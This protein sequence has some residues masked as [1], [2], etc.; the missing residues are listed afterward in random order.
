[1]KTFV[2]FA[3]DTQAWSTDVEFARRMLAGL[4]PLVITLLKVCLHLKHEG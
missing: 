1:M 3:A 2:C 4:N